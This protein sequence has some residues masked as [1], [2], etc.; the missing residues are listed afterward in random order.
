MERTGQVENEDDCVFVSSFENGA[1]GVFWA[2]R[3]QS[4]QRLVVYGSKGTL[5][6][7]LNGDKLLGKRGDAA[8]SEEIPVPAGAAVPTIVSQFVAGIQAD[9]ERPPS[10]Y[11]GLKAQEVIEA[12]LQSARER[13]W[14]SIAEVA[15]DA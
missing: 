14:V 11:D 1:Y 2:S 9:S 8:G 12:V 13:R 4:E 5:A 3:M 6:W 7:R 10:F 15:R